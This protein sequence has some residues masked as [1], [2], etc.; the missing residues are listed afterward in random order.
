MEYVNQVALCGRVSHA[1]EER[2]LPSGDKVHTWRLV[3]ER[4]PGAVATRARR[5]T[6]SAPASVGKGSRTKA[7]DVIDVACWSAATRR[8]ASRLEVG[9]PVQVEGAL[10]RRFYRGSAGV[11][12]RTEVEAFAVRRLTIAVGDSPDETA[13]RRS[14]RSP[15]R[16]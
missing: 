15:G 10:R 3:V 13:N 16:P 6:S 11:Q 2:E 7:L 5:R 8:V 4:D 9:T 12:S 1:G 14:R